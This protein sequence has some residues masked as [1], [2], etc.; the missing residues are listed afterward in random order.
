MILQEIIY[1]G[2][3]ETQSLHINRRRHTRHPLRIHGEQHI[4]PGHRH[5]RLARHLHAVRIRTTSGE[6]QRHPQLIRIHAMRRRP[7]AHHRELLHGALG[8]DRQRRPQRHVPGGARA[9]DL[10]PRRRRHRRA[11]GVEQVRRPEDLRVVVVR[12]APHAAQP[13]AAAE[14][15]PVRQQHGHAV[16]VPRDAQ[17]RHHGEGVGGRVEELRVQDRGVVAED[18]RVVEPADDEHAAVGEHDAVVEGPRVVRAVDG[19][20]GRAGVGRPQRDDVRVGG[21][22]GAVVVQRP[23]DGEDLPRHRVVHDGNPVHGVDVVGAG[24]G[25]RGRAWAVGAEPVHVFRRARVEDGAVLAREEPG[26][27]VLAVDA[28]VVVGEDGCDR[29][30]GPQG[31]GVRDGV[32]VFGVFAASRSAPGATGG[33]DSTVR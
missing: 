15:R 7:E 23:A 14:H 6:R 31:P 18:A 16:V 25:R 22:E 8:R 29:A 32:V 21:G 27:V 5:P 12:R 3:I 28:L 9:R 20:D 10:R 2:N 19:R 17:R 1:T 24:A 13:A 4:P 11:V 30:A 33:E 26:V